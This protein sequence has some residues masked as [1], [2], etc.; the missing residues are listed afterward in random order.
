MPPPRIAGGIDAR[1][2]QLVHVLQRESRR[3]MRDFLVR[4]YALHRGKHAARSQQMFRGS[5]EFAEV[6]EGG[7]VYYRITGP[8]K[9]YFG[10]APCAYLPDDRTIVAFSLSRARRALGSV[11]CA[12]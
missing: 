1:H 11:V 4:M 2:R 12:L 8:L 3:E 9:E 10:R 7:H 6:R 5:R